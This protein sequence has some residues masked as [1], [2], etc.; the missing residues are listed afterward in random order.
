M[1]AFYDFNSIYT[2]TRSLIHE[3]LY[4]RYTMGTKGFPG[5][6]MNGF[7][8]FRR[9]V[10]NG[11]GVTI[12]DA[13]ETFETRFPAAECSSANVRNNRHSDDRRQIAKTDLGGTTRIPDVPRFIIE[14]ER[15]DFY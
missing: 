5:K 6:V 13:G 2:M 12:V 15:F 11:V 8:V 7:P 9:I 4:T 10:D 14:L 3:Y 1:T